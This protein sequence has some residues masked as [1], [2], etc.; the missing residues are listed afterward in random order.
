MEKLNI[1]LIKKLKK[2]NSFLKSYKK[3]SVLITGTTGFKGSWLAFW[4]T[5]LGAKVTGISFK[6]EKNSV[7]FKS[8]LLNKKI[9]Q[10][11][12][13]IRNFK[14]LNQTIKKVKPDIIFHLAAQSI[15][16]KSFSNPLETI[17]TNILGSANILECHRLNNIP[18]L[19]YI[20][21]D[22]CYLNLNKKKDYKEKDIL[23]GLDNYSSSKASAEII[24][25]SFFNSYFKKK[26]YLTMA[27]ARAGNVIGGGDMKMNRILPD[28][29]N[30][31]KNKRKLILRNPNAT[32][33]W[34]HVLEPLS[35]YLILGDKLLNKKIKN[36]IAPNWNFGPRSKNCKTV[37]KITSLVFKYWGKKN[38]RFLK[39]KK[40]TY[41][42]S[43]F[44]SL[45]I[46]KAKRELNW[47]PRLGLEETIK[48]TTDWY[49][50]YYH[51]NKIENLT[52]EQIQY[53]LN[54]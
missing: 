26:T 40:D 13:D 9:D 18:C 30:S 41:H 50:N 15:V 23:G 27:S 3:L 34:Q 51:N 8:L 48:L 35:G 31:L 14:K 29:I 1:R 28:I 24:F 11:Y 52:L 39:N 47:K 20:T 21:S 22:K 49:R 16:S 42:E 6:P 33:P 44:L 45:N 46:S 12:F 10:R 54:K 4:L 17:E 43:K 25:S 38:V 2:N 36:N 5:S 53:F 37:R 7:L 19:V 32:R